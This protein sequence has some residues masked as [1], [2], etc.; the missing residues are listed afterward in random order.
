MLSVAIMINGNPVM[1]RSATK[2]DR[3]N[4]MDKR[5]TAYLV[6]DGSLVWHNPKDGAVA[7]A[8]KLLATIK[9]QGVERTK[10]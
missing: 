2:Q 9:E 6:D 1:A 5:Q 3:R 7:L 8:V 10:D 4:P